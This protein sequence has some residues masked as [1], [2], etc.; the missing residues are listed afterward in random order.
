MLTARSQSLLQ[1][2]LWQKVNIVKFA[3]LSIAVVVAEQVSGQVGGV[4]P[5]VPVSVLGAAIG[6]YVSFRTNAAYDRWWEGRKLWGQLTNSCRHLTAEV[7][8]YLPGADQGATRRRLVQRLMVY[9]HVLRCELWGEARERDPDLKRL[10]KEHA[11]PEGDEGNTTSLLRTQLEELAALAQAGQLDARR[12][13]SMDQ[14][15]AVL[16]DVQGG[17][18]RI[19][20]TPFPPGYGF[21]AEILIR[22]YAVFLPLA[23]VDDLRWWAIPVSILVCLAFKLVSEVGRALEE[24]FTSASSALPLFAMSS[25]IER[26]LRD[27]LGDP[28]HP[29]PCPDHKGVLK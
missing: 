18:E 4:L 14:T 8:A 2:L 10:A 21:I 23:I 19:K 20:N 22:A 27:A 11:L 1:I 12:L 29:V 26:N 24:P 9:V 15:I 25:S 3:L 13:Q 28:G 17:C 5:D 6:I 16:Y 7:L